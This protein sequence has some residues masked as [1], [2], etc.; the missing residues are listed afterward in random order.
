M[1]HILNYMVHALHLLQLTLYL[2]S[3][4]ICAIVNIQIVLLWLECRHGYVSTTGHAMTSSVTV[5]SIPAH[6]SI[7]HCLKSFTFLHFCPVDSLLNYSPN[8]VNWTEV[9]AVRRPQFW[10]DE[11]IVVGIIQLLHVASLQTLLTMTGQ[12][13]LS[14]RFN[15]HFPGEPGL[16]GIY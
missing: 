5:G 1:L 12:S 8:V 16:G 13:H 14:L 7:R 11:C 15:D 2:T 3:R 10:H 6:T 9:M 4:L